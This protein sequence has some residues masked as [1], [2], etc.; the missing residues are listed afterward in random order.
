ML[1]DLKQIAQTAIGVDDTTTSRDV[2]SGLVWI[3]L[4]G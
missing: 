3:K 2:T 4:R 1:T